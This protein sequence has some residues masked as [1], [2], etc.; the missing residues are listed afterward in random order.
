[1]ASGTT[2]KPV[3]FKAISKAIPSHQING[4]DYFEWSGTWA[5]DVHED[6][7]EPIAFTRVYTN[8]S[9]AVIAG[10]N[11][12]RDTEKV[13]LLIKNVS[14]SAIQVDS[15]NVTILYAKY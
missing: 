2:R 4:N 14:A 12:S 15:G 5:I 8:R 7:W 3:Q 9:N 13:T 11:L 6:G 1:M 10:F